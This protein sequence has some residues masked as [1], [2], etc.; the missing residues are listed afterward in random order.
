MRNTGPHVR[1]GF[2]R[3]RIR[4]SRKFNRTQILTTGASQKKIEFSTYDTVHIYI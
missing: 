4:L 3:I 1:T 2:E